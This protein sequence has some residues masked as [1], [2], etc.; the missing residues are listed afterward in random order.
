MSSTTTTPTEKLNFGETFQEK[1]ITSLLHNKDFLLQVC[2]ILRPDYYETESMQWLVKTI[3]D[4]FDEYKCP[5]TYEV[6]AVKV[7]SIQLDSL[8]ADTIK[9]IKSV[10]KH[11]D[12][13]DLSFI[14]TEILKFCKN[15]CLKKAILSSVSYL[16]TGN[17]EAIKYEID[18]AIKSGMD[19]RIGHDYTTEVAARYLDDMRNT[20]PT[21]WK[22]INDITDGG[23][24]QGEMVVVVA[25]PGSGKS[26]V[27]ANIGARAMVAGLNV[28]HYTLELSE[29]YVAMRYDSILTE[30]PSDE[31]KK[32][33]LNNLK[34]VVSELTGTMTVKFYPSKSASVN[35]IRAHIDRC[36]MLGKKPDVVIVDYA[37]LL[38]GGQGKEARHALDSIYTDLRG[39]AGEYQIPLFT[40]SQSNRSSA[41]DDVIE[42]DK[43]AESY[44]KVMVADFVMSL[45][46]KKEDKVNGTGRFYI[47]K[48]R[49]G[50]DGQT[51]AAN[52]NMSNGRIDILDPDSKES[53]NMLQ[54]T[55]EV[56][57]I[58]KTLRERFDKNA[59]SRVSF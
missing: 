5:P 9:T 11:L 16:E 58:K 17:Y 40:A 42:A 21:P 23:F 10:A 1:S 45:S 50:K 28:N 59:A 22:A 31:I 39:L 29:S 49:Y 14:Q 18:S 46:R 52:I 34:S 26:W 47:I 38:A 33:D 19:K 43:I 48:N 53:Q 27:L 41:Q 13:P 25:G 54:P 8:R 32:S 51:F 55:K 44:S 3:L 6:L 7:K 2:D 20:R 57:D 30:M 12:S 24:G 36:I 15:Q 56:D 37:D 4:Y 35:T